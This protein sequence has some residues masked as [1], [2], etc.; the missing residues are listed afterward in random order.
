[1]EEK[2]IDNAIINPEEM[3]SPFDCIK[4]VDAEGREW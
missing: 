4:E 1:M 3:L 2:N